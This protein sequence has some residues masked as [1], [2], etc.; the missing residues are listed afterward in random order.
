MSVGGHSRIYLAVYGLEIIAPLQKITTFNI[1]TRFSDFAT[2]YVF[3][4]DFS[5]LQYCR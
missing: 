2:F 5:M 4:G 3:G 1:G